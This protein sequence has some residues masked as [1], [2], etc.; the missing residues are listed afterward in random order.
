[1]KARSQCPCLVEQEYNSSFLR[2]KSHNLTFAK[3]CIKDY[4]KK[5]CFYKILEKDMQLLSWHQL[6]GELLQRSKQS[7]RLFSSTDYWSH[8]YLSPCWDELYLSSINFQIYY[9]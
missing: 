7:V 6:D 2:H 9:F 3:S 4:E 8:Q 5:S 1:M